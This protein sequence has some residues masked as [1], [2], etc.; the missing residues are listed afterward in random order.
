MITHVAIIFQGRTWALPTPPNRHHHVISL[1]F[2]TTG[3]P[4]DDDIQGFMTHDGNFLD[5]KAAL[6]H[7]KACNQLRDPDNH[8]GDQLFSEDLWLNPPVPGDDD[9]PN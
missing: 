1:I 7:A 2:Q 9:N 8:H 6:V 5:R 3:L 4:V